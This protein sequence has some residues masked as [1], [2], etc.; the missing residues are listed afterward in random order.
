MLWMT[1]SVLQAQSVRWIS[2]TEGQVWKET[3]VKMQ[4][5]APQT[6]LLEV[7]GTEQ[8]TLFRHWGTTFNELCWDALSVL[9]RNEQDEILFNF[10]DPQGDLRFTRGRI[11]LGANDYARSWYSCDE[12]EGDFELRYFNIERDKQAV[13]PYIRAAQKYNPDLTFWI[14][15]WCPPSWMKINGDYPVLSSP[16][17]RLPE[18]M[19]YLLYGSSDAQTDPDEMKLTGEREGVFPRRLATTDFMIQDPRYLQTYANYFCR[20]IDAYAGQGIPIDMVMY[21]NE[22]YSYTPF[23][24]CAWTAAGTIRFNKE[25]LAPT[26]KRLHPEVKLYLGTFNT[27]RNLC[28]LEFPTEAKR[29]QVGN[30]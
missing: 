15:P 1:A 7:E 8:G 14:S 23:P 30:C 10:F 25:Y 2:S 29:I 3:K 27:N 19:N 9:S 11:S 22:A 24:G 5:S 20:F 4:A 26:L 16:Y 17:N 18:K 21:Q 28:N 13:I 6:P 12:M